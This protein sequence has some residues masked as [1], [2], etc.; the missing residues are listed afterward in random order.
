MTLQTSVLNY[1]LSTIA[2]ATK[3]EAELASHTPLSGGSI[4]TVFLLETSAGNFV[5]KLNKAYRYKG[6]FEAEAK[7]L[8]MLADTNTLRTPEV[9]DV[10]HHEDHT[11]LLCE[12]IRN[13]EKH[14]GFWETFGSK[15]AR[16]HRHHNSYFGLDHDNYIGSLPQQNTRH[17]SWE[18]FFVLQRLQP[19]LKMAYDSGCFRSKDRQ[20]MER[21]MG[22]IGKLI[23]EE[24]AALIHGDLWSG[25][26]LIDETSAPVLIDPAIYYGHRE[27]DIAMMHLFGGFS[28]V[29]FQAYQSEFPMEKGWKERI[30]L[31]NLYPLL[32][33]VNLFGENYLGQVRS[34]LRKFS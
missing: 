22:K 18:D 33:H 12:H 20:M 6:M 2:K 21:L 15:L 13:G 34:T 30:P 9:I 17:E 24:K 25:N 1:L 32:V 16:L 10:G 14:D 29:L 3:T 5:V 11:Y 31:H 27:M 26:Y 23:P 4:N 19:Q 7:G 8:Q 28:P